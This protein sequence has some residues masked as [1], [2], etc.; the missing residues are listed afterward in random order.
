M[1]CPQCHSKK[2]H[3]PYDGLDITDRYQCADCGYVAGESK[4]TTEHKQCA[5]CMASSADTRSKLYILIT[6][7]HEYM[8][9]SDD[10]K[11]ALKYVREEM[12]DK[13]GDPVLNSEK[14]SILYHLNIVSTIADYW[15]EGQNERR[16]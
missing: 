1:I 8:F 13:H 10:D 11:Q 15:D 2:D 7:K 9:E 12:K 14:P 6:S 4:F 5:I 16:V 3:Q